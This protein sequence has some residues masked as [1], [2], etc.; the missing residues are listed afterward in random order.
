MKRVAN[1]KNPLTVPIGISNR[2]VHLS[3]N[4]MEI[5]F[6]KGYTLTKMRDLMQPGQFAVH[7]TVTVIGPKG[8]IENV[9][10]IGP[11]RE[12]TQV[13]ISL[14][15]S[16]LLGLEVPLRESGKIEGTPGI[17][18]KGPMGTVETKEGIIVAQRHIHMPTDYAMKY[19]FK[20]N[21]IVSV[22]VDGPRKLVYHNV[23]VRVSDRFA[24]EMHLDTDEANAAGVSNGGTGKVIKL[25]N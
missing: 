9:R 20:D 17:T 15:E 18:L 12:Q 23:L 8:S 7:E 22:E 11:V 4:D 1:K 5:L 14:T 24:L 10:I 16:K 2:H 13:E 3:K 25:N 6:G 21:E 19:G